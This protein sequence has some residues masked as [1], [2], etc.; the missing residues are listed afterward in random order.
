MHTPSANFDQ[1]W[2]KS[3]SLYI[4]NNWHFITSFTLPRVLMDIPR[5]AA[6]FAGN[7]DAFKVDIDKHV[8]AKEYFGVTTTPTI[9]VYK[10]GSQLK[11]VEG[12]GQENA[13]AIA[14]VLV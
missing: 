7:T 2:P 4:L 13:E 5:N 9:V 12:G 11:K 10:D 14:S 6:K 3:L 1:E 8:A